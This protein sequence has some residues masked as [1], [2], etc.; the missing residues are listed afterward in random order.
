MYNIQSKCVQKWMYACMYTWLYTYIHA[1]YVAECGRARSRVCLTTSRQHST[2][3]QKSATGYCACNEQSLHYT[4]HDR[5]MTISFI[6]I[7]IHGMHSS[8][9]KKARG[10]GPATALELGT[11]AL[12]IAEFQPREPQR[13]VEIFRPPLPLCTGHRCATIQRHL[14]PASR[15]CYCVLCD[16]SSLSAA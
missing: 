6:S 8:E 13:Q 14:R 15:G 3:V 9:G 10:K 7:S 5:Y 4:I 16:G 12:Y 11:Y 1:A 2:G